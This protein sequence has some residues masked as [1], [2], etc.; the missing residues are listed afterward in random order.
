[1][2]IGFP[3]K[4]LYRFKACTHNNTKSHTELQC[5]IFYIGC[6][7]VTRLQFINLFLV[8]IFKSQKNAYLQLNAEKVKY[9]Q[10]V[11]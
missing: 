8:M 10:R 5:S 1:M 7:V 11:T 6:K 4:T 2:G 9:H 3:E